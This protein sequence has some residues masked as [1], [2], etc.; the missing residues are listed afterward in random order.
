M[1]DSAFRSNGTIHEITVPTCSYR[2]GSLSPSLGLAAFY[3]PGGDN[4][5]VLAY[6]NLSLPDRFAALRRYYWSPLTVAAAVAAKKAL[7][8]LAR[9]AR[10]AGGMAGLIPWR[11][12]ARS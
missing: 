3:L 10:G 8:A 5:G 9:A 7:A 12:R 2:M 6:Y 11:K 4:A 1:C